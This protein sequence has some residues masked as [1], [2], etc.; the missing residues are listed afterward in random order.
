MVSGLFALVLFRFGPGDGTASV[1][2]VG[3]LARPS[4]AG[5]GQLTVVT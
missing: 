2:T 3:G 5:S 1:A 4:A